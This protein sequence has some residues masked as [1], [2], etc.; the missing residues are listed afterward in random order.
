MSIVKQACA[1]ATRANDGQEEGVENWQDTEDREG[2][3]DVG[4]YVGC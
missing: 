4:D 1:D 3:A 2:D